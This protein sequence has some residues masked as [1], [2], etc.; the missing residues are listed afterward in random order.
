MFFVS[1]GKRSVQTEE[2]VAKSLASKLAL[3]ILKQRRLDDLS[4]TAAQRDPKPPAK[5]FA[6]DGKPLSVTFRRYPEI[7][8]RKTWVC[9]LISLG[10]EQ[11]QTDQLEIT[12]MV[13]VSLPLLLLTNLRH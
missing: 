1:T 2:A 12:P 9:C 7:G 8:W 3:E 11:Y 4:R 6:E 5:L 10:T 13:P